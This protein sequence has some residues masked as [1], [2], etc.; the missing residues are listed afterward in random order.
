MS[1]KLGNGV[2]IENVDGNSILITERGDA[3]VLNETG[4]YILDLLLKNN[5]YEDVIDK[6]KEIYKVDSNIVGNDV[7]KL[8]CELINKGL[9]DTF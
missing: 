8:V 6:I 2:T 7:Q 1:Y 9:I 5:G 3:A 4:A